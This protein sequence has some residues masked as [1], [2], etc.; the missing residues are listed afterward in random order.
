MRAPGA[1]SAAT[2]GA[3]Q[4]PQKRNPGGLTPPHDAHAVPSAEPQ[5]PQNAV[6]LGFSNPQGVHCIGRVDFG[7]GEVEIGSVGRIWI[8]F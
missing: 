3:P 7:S 1:G 8:A 6:P 2:S 4:C 5:P